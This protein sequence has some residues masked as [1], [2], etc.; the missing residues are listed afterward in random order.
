[1]AT[2]LSG[3]VLDVQ[4]MDHATSSSLRDPRRHD[5]L[6]NYQFKRL[7]ALG[8]APAVRL[9]EGQFGIAR[10]EWR[11]LAGLVEGGPMSPSTLV[12]RTGMDQARASK[13]VASLVHKKL[14][15][16]QPDAADRRRCALSATT[17]GKTLYAQLFPQLAEINRRLASVLDDDELQVFERCL[18]KLTDHARQLSVDGAGVSVKADRRLGGSRRVWDARN[19]AADAPGA[20][21]R[22]SFPF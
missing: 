21:G 22:R 8:G 5:D 17:A 6:L 4:N 19:L 2:N 1:M 12:T 14:A 13:A 7:L 16:K 9:C 11:M 3:I 15:A 18:R 20:N 10:L